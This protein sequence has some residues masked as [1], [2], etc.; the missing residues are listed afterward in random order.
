MIVSI[1]LLKKFNELEILDIFRMPVPLKNPKVPEDNLPNMVP[2]YYLEANS[3]TVNLDQMRYVLLSKKEQDHCSSQLNLY[4]DV[5][6][7]LYPIT[8]RKPCIVALFL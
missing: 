3:I 7:L 5:Q 1:P 6:R 8:S 2:W 4:C